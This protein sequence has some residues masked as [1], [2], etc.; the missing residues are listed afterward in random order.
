MILALIFVSILCNLNA[1]D[2]ILTKDGLIIKA[3]IK[4]VGYEVIEFKMF[5]N[6]DGES[7]FIKKRNIESITYENGKVEN[8]N[9]KEE[10]QKIIFAEK[11]NKYENTLGSLL[12]SGGSFLLVG[13]AFHI[14]NVS[15]PYEKNKNS[16]AIS[17]IGYSSIGV[18]AVLF[19]TSGIIY[20]KQNRLKKG[21]AIM[22]N[23]NSLSLLYKF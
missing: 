11:L 2:I 12:W 14:I 17:I 7:E 21:I 1:Q 9:K 3:K 20:E 15:I 18:S 8:F 5:N 19:I 23:G 10:L 13:A 22:G 6:Q 16:K 4:S